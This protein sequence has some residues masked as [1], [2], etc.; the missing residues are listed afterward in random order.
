MSIVLGVYI[1]VQEGRHRLVWALLDGN[2]VLEQ[3]ELTSPTAAET[4]RLAELD[5]RFADLLDRLVGGT[6]PPAGIA[7]RVHDIHGARAESILVPAHAEGVVLAIA[8]KRHMKVVQISTQK[9]GGRQVVAARA[10]GLQ[11]TPADQHAAQAA[12]A[13]LRA[14]ADIP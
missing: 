8:G 1:H 7:L 9:L 6:K 4:R 12:V 10:R 11:P 2:S 14:A 5:V 13:A 3:G